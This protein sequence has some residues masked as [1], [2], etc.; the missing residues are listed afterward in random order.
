MLQIEYLAV[1]LS[2]LYGGHII[3]VIDLNNIFVM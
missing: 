2:E 1:Y 3:P